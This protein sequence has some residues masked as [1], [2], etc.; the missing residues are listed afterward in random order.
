MAIPSAQTTNNPNHILAAG[1]E[2]ISMMI[3]A[4]RPTTSPP[5]RVAK[6]PEIGLFHQR[7]CRFILGKDTV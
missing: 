2:R 3:A 6:M 7:L 1:D 4:A 5:A